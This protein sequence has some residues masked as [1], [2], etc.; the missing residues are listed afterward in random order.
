MKETKEIAA[1]IQLIDDPDETIYS[2]VEEKLR[3]YGNAIISNLETAWES[4]DNPLIQER[5]EMLIHS[6][7]TA[8]IKTDLHQW[9]EKPEP[10]L[11]EGA[12]ILSHYHFP[13]NDL[14]IIHQQIEKLRRSIWL[15]LSPHLT[16]LEQTNVLTG[17]LFQYCHFKQTEMN[18]E[19]PGDFLISVLLE[20]KK[21]NALSLTILQ[22]ILAELNDI[23]L[24]LIQIPGQL[25]MGYMTR[26]IGV[27]GSTVKDDIP[28]YVDGGTGQ[29]YSYEDIDTYLKKIGAE[30]ADHFFVP[31]TTKEIIS[32]LIEEYARCFQADEL[33]YKY[34]ELIALAETL[35]G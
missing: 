4:T 8:Q 3:S 30:Y 2:S 27:D 19:R 16:A 17:Y 20:Q 24:R 33:L 21:G 32:L 7:Q 18:H 1:L 28:F 26:H 35:K 23:P 13:E 9:A 10:E 29:I 34:R 11:L 31:L 5:I 22:L 12:C 25:M 6:V 15:E 14:S